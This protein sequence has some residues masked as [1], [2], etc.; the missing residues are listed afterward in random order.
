VTEREGYGMVIG[1]VTVYTVVSVSDADALTK[2][3][4]VYHIISQTSKVS[5]GL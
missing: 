2:W 3:T 4:L 5:M 1:V